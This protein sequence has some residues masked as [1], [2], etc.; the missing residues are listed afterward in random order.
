MRYAIVIRRRRYATEKRQPLRH[1]EPS[2]EHTTTFV[3]LA[4]PPPTT[5]A[6]SAEDADTAGDFSI[7]AGFHTPPLP[8]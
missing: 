4:A 6:D 7:A 8:G 3:R 5:M 2:T 1:I